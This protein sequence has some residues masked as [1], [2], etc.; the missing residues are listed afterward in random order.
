MGLTFHSDGVGI[1]EGSEEVELDYPG[2]PPP[3]I[4]HWLG[5]ISVER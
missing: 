1:G 4:A 3:T 5:F 2:Y